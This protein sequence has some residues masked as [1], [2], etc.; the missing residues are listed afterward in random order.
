LPPGARDLA[1]GKNI[2]VMLAEV[3]S[4]DIAAKKFGMPD[5]ELD[6]DFLILATGA[7]ILISGIRNGSELLLV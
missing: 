7:G 2:E 6:Y 3:E 4:I 5:A 1:Q